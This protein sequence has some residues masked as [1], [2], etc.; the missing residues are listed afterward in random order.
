MTRRRTSSRPDSARSS[1]GRRSRAS[2]VDFRIS[3][4]TARSIVGVALLV[5]G[6][7]TL[8]ALMLPAGGILNRLVADVLR[9]SFGQG[10]WLLPLV[11]LLAGVLVERA[12]RAGNGW[13]VTAVGGFVAF[14][15]ALGLIHLVWGR[16]GTAAALR[17]GGGW[18]G[19]QLATVLSQWISPA[20]ALVVLLGL[21]ITGV[22]L[23]FS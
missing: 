13:G 2:T 6:A 17:A 1:R 22:L 9:P 12:P 23:L 16:G 14:V 10:A 19:F 20:G 8:I 18:I 3:P 4:Q 7:V 5:S 15:G 21:L 11:L